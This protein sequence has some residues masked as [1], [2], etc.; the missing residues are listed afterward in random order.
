MKLDFNPM[1]GLWVRGLVELKHLCIT[2]NFRDKARLDAAPTYPQ[3]GVGMLFARAKDT[4]YRLYE[5]PHFSFCISFR[6]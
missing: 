1:H 4:H 2:R 5:R 6:Q 3:A